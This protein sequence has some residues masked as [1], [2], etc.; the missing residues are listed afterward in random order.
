MKLGESMRARLRAL[1]GDE[2]SRALDEAAREQGERAASFAGAK[3]R[4]SRAALLHGLAMAGAGALVLGIVSSLDTRGSEFLARRKVTP[5]PLAAAP[6]ALAAVSGALPVSACAG[7]S[8]L[9]FPAGSAERRLDLGTRALLVANR[10]AIVAATQ[11]E[12]CDLRAVLADGGLAVHARNLEGRSLVVTTPRGDIRAEGA[13]FQ[14]DYYATSAEL[15]VA[16]EEG[17]VELVGHEG[18]TVSLSA[19]EAA[20]V[21]ARVELEPFE[22]SERAHLRRVLGLSGK[23]ARGAEPNA[24]ERGEPK[25]KRRSDARREAQQQTEQE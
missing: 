24:A 19:G 16:V 4:K 11:T 3:E 6:P 14:V 12:D 2:P 18:Q 13:A 15:T 7:S 17:R 9:V 10:P 22:E 8:S 5:A 25:L 23:R 21:G 20:Y 1:A